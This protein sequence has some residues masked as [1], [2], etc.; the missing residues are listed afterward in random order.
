MQLLEEWSV[1]RT[2]TWHRVFKKSHSKS[3]LSQSVWDF[4]KDDI[5]TQTVLCISA[6][7]HKTEGLKAQTVYG[8]YTVILSDVDVHKNY[9]AL[10][11]S[12]TMNSV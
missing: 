7:I 9:V 4:E 1:S 12:V 8:S 5:H 11:R 2:N 10:K 3:C 6:A